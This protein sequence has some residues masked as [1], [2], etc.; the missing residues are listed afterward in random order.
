V[1]DF[2]NSETMWLNLTNAT[3]GV[4]TLVCLVAVARIFIPELFAI[5]AAKRAR[6]AVENDSHAFDLSGLGITMADGGERIDES[7]R[8]RSDQDDDPP[9]IIR[10]T[11]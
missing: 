2:L 10:S 6:V 5:L 4:V 9:N 7:A 8:R 11:N 1:F 3:L